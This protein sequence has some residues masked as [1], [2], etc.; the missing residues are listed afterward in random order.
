MRISDWSSDVC[1]SDL[2]V[3]R[4]PQMA[5]GG[6]RRHALLQLLE[7]PG[8]DLAHA[9]AAHA[10]FLAQLLQSQRIVAQAALAQDMPLAVGELVH[11]LDHEDAAVEIGRA[12][13]RERVCRYV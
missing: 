6:Q 5:L 8:L 10:I 4:S 11:G 9:L 13:G 7:G 12:S 3:S 1:S 2:V